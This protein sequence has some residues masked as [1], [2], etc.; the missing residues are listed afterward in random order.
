MTE[1]KS[2]FDKLDCIKEAHTNMNNTIKFSS[3]KNDD[4]GHAEL[5]PIFQYIVI[6][7]QPKRIH[8]DINYIKCFLGDSSLRGQEGFLVTQMESA[9]SFITLINH[10]HLKMTKE[11]YDEKILD[12]KK[13]H[14]IK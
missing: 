12:A 8:S 9:T 6:K 3:G 10:T 14:G 11:E 1:A 13:R 5:T 4:A 7:A 2:V